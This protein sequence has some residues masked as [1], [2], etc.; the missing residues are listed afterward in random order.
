MELRRG[1]NSGGE[2]PEVVRLMGLV[3]D[4]IRFVNGQ[5]YRHPHERC[6]A[7]AMALGRVMGSTANNRKALQAGIHDLLELAQEGASLHMSQRE[8]G[9]AGP[10]P[11]V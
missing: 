6:K 11:V 10:P 2:D 3:N 8:R 7:V 5:K 9:E 1:G 4:I